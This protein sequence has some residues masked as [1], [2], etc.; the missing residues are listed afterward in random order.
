MIVGF[1]K[2]GRGSAARA[3]AYLTDEQTP[4]GALKYVLGERNRAGVV[5]DPAPV[6]L[7]GDPKLIARVIDGSSHQWKYTSG[8]LSF[9]PG[10]R[11]TPA[12]ETQFMD[13]FE[14]IAFAGLQPARYAIL[15]VRHAHAGHPEMHF[16]TPRV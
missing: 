14:A 8:V 4:G 6:V 9:A 16:I 2:H 11:I 5:R 1:S 13:E 12:Q 15:W 3:V 10:E 7:R